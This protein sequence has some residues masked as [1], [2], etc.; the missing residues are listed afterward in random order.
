M[1]SWGKS[2]KTRL[3]PVMKCADYD[4]IGFVPKRAGRE[5]LMAFGQGYGARFVA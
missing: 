3:S 4:T 5:R 1:F 2:G